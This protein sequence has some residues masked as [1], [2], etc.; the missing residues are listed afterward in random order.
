MRKVIFFLLFLGI[1]QMSAQMVNFNLSGAGARA[2]GMG[3][4]FIGVA[5]DATAIAWNPAGLSQLERPEFS[6]VGRFISDSY[7]VN[8]F[9]DKS[10]NTQDHFVMNFLSAALPI[11]VGKYNLVGAIALQR[12]IDLFS[13]GKAYDDWGAEFDF[14]GSGGVDS[15]TF[16][17]SFQALPWLNFGVAANLWMGSY[18]YKENYRADYKYTEE[19]SGFNLVTGLMINLNSLDSPLPIKL[20]TVFRTPFELEIESKDEFGKETVKFDMPSMV[21]FGV[22]I[23]PAELFTIAADYEM[24][25]YSEVDFP[26]DMNQ[27]R[28]G[29][30]YLLLTDFAV[31]PLRAGFFTHPTFMQDENEDQVSGVGISLG[32]GLIFERFA[33][34]LGLSGNSAEIEYDSDFTETFTQGILALSAIFYF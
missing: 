8:W 3:G 31:I 21:G 6:I 22:S 18:E 17:S 13:E 15:F 32:T 10:E 9:G 23:Q 30:E 28:I 11:K 33:L 27:L 1:V 25:Y 14:E 16:G 24:R 4:A 7:E 29:T 5:D 26:F 19:Y 34:D 12:Q 2:M 20:G